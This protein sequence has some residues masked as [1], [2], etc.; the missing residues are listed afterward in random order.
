MKRLL[1]LSLVL[2]AGCVHSDPTQ[3][4]IMEQRL[5]GSW[6]MTDLSINGKNTVKESDPVFKVILNPD[7][8]WDAISYDGSVM[9]EL[10]EDENTKDI[11][12]YSKYIV[13]GNR[14]KFFIFAEN[15]RVVEVST[16]FNLT[17]KF[18]TLSDLKMNMSDIG[19]V[20]M[21][22]MFP[23]VKRVTASFIIRN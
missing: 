1:L 22:A 9:E 14:L 21:S 23:D 3:N 19:K 7:R 10:M 12:F 8:S 15:G 2:L 16:K 20:N 4:M 6:E 5:I 18:L 11:E 13:D 17:Q